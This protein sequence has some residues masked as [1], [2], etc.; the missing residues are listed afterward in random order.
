MKK[1]VPSEKT[2]VK[3]HEFVKSIKDYQEYPK[4]EE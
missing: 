4:L 1:F 2:L 3:L